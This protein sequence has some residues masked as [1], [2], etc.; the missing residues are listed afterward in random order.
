M[1]DEKILTPAQQA[2][3]K[4]LQCYNKLHEFFSQEHGLI[5]TTGEMDDILRAC[6]NFRKQWNEGIKEPLS[7]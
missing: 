2:F 7:Y 3:R 6:D 4:E 5:L 1:A